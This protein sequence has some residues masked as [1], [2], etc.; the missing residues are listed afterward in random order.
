MNLRALDTAAANPAAPFL[1]VN[2]ADDDSFRFGII[3]PIGVG[4]EFGDISDL[5]DQIDRAEAILD[6]T[7]TTVGAAN[8][9]ITEV[10]SILNNIA[11]TAYVKVSASTQIP[12]MPIIYKTE[13]S[14]AFLVD[15]SVS[16]VG[17]GSLLASDVTVDTSG[18]SPELTSNTSMYAN[19]ATDL[20]I[21]VGYSQKMWE[22][23]NS[24]AGMLIGGIKANFHQ[25]SLGQALS[26]L[27]DDSDDA[28]DVFSDTISDDAESTT[29]VGIDLGAIWYSDIYHAGITIANINEPEFDYNAVGTNCSVKTGSA[30]TSCD[31]AASFISAGK[32]TAK[33]TYVMEMQTTLDFSI[34]T[35][36]KQLT[37]GLSYDVNEVEDAVGDEYQWA[38]ASLSYYGDSH[39]LP[40]LRVGMRQNMAGTE[41]S[42]VTAGLTLLKRLN[43]DVAVATDTVTDDDGDEV[44]RSAFVSLGYNTAF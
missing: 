30:K 42:Y 17:R 29:G 40:G 28:S 32:L 21:G 27:S 15:A 23:E 41:L 34:S 4:A 5:D 14:G 33:N 38:V 1:M 11:D 2:D 19:V 6:A 13:S 25:I 37:L 12:L 7:Y 24:D 8:N 16:I 44:P 26:V 22:P 3:G 20:N 43:L 36:Q 10:N 31:A 18:A 9:A 35:P 39:F